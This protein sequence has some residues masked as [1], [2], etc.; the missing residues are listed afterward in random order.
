MQGRPETKIWVGRITPLNE[1]KCAREGILSHISTA[2]ANKNQMLIIKHNI[3]GVPG[4]YSVNMQA[5]KT[6][7]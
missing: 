4:I 1:R 5:A 2:H 7:N 6:R 3:V